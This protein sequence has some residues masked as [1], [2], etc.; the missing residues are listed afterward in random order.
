MYLLYIYTIEF[1]FF[2]FLPKK[3]K[4]YFYI[5]IRVIFFTQKTVLHNILTHTPKA[6]KI[7]TSF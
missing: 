3:T 2:L 5:K 6:I 4:E 1:F 7:M